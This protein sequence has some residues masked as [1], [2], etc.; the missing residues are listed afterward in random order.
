[1]GP[2][3][4]PGGLGTLWMG[5]CLTG[6]SRRAPG[7]GHWA[8]IQKEAGVIALHDFWMVGCQVGSVVWPKEEVVETEVTL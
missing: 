4:V 3:Q 7:N 5:L 1:M 6:G 8:L 2:D